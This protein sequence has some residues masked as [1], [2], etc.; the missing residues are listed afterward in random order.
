MRKPYIARHP[1]T[2]LTKYK[3]GQVKTINGQVYIVTA[4]LPS[5]P[6][7]FK[8]YGMLAG[9]AMKLNEYVDYQERR[10]KGQVKI[11]LPGKHILTV[12]VDHDK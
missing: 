12:T 4:I 10:E 7:T 2:N 1:F 8:V 3:I 9:T 5:T 11:Y 6:K